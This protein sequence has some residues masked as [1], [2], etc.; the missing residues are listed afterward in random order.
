MSN[1]SILRDE[2]ALGVALGTVTA[3]AFGA[4]AST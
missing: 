3:V 4:G 2:V 1:G